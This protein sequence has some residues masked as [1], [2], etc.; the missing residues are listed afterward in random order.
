MIEN[1]TSDTYSTTLESNVRISHNKI[2]QDYTAAD[3]CKQSLAPNTT[4]NHQERKSVT[5][6][7]DIEGRVLSEFQRDSAPLTVQKIKN[8]HNG[9]EQGTS[10]KQTQMETVDTIKQQLSTQDEEQFAQ[11]AEYEALP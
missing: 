11:I 8:V 4:I 3:L 9:G 5:C 7:N 2:F 6:S 1:F 10:P